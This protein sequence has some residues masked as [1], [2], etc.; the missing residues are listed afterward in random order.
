MNRALIE[1]WPPEPAPAPLTGPLY[2]D[3]EIRPNRSLPDQGFRALMIALCALGLAA[4]GAFALIGAWPVAGFFGLDILLVW[5]A[6]RLSYRDGRRLETIQVT[7]DE[8]RVSRRY[9]NGRVTSFRLPGA[10]TRLSVAGAGQAD[11]QARLS[12]MGKHLVIGSFLSPRERESLAAAV[13]DALDRARRPKRS[14]A[15]FAQESGGRP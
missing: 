3:A 15:A 4:G 10:W 7:A 5:L 12:A 14:G 1:T 2:L 13:Q 9:P 11:V 6:F 8:I